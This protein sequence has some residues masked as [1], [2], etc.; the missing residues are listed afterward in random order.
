M[1]IFAVRG[2]ATVP[3]YINRVLATNPIAY[4]PLNETAGNTAVCQVN[5]AQNGTYARNVTLMGTGAGIADG[6]AAPT[7]DGTNDF[8]NIYTAALAAAFNGATGSALIWF[9]VAN[10]GIWTDATQRFLFYLYSDANNRYRAQRVITNSRL[11]ATGIAGAGACTVN[12]DGLA[13]TG[14]MPVVITW[15]DGANAD[16]L[17]Y[18]YNGVAVAAPCAT[19]NNWAGALAAAFTLIGAGT[20]VPTLVWHGWLSHMAV[21]DTVL[22]PATITELSTI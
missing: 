20:N 15:S 7:F 19:M 5:A 2:A 11:Q 16:E 8:V 12:R 14:W 10:V 1:I 3:T 21:W 6:N 4:W 13:D 22:P 9:R 18:Y 17:I